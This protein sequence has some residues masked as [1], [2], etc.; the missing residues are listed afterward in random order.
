[1]MMSMYTITKEIHFCYG[2]R[3][4]GHHGKCRHLHGHSARVEIELSAAKLN[5]QG[6]VTDFGKVK[7]LLK[8][9]I[10]E[11]LDHRMILCAKDPLVSVLKK[12][13]EPL[14][15][16]KQPP[17]AENIARLIFEFARKSSL[18]VSK[19]TLWEPP[20]SFASYCR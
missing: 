5:S 8:N 3:L 19:V 7:A 1:M 16:L 12:T 6:M 10:D 2:H 11:N 9:W 20:T 13:E 17:T 15:I 18:P 14:F 4:P